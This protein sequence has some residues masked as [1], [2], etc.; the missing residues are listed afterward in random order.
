MKK[1]VAA[2]LLF[3]LCITLCACGSAAPAD[4]AVSDPAVTDASPFSVD[5]SAITSE[6]DSTFAPDENISVEVLY[7]EVLLDLD[8]EGAKYVAE[9]KNT[10][11]F[12]I[13]ISN[14]SIDVEKEDGTLLKVV[15]YISAYPSIIDAGESAFICESIVTMLDSDIT[16]S[17]ATVA[18]LKFK[19]EKAVMPELD[20]ELLTIN[21]TVKTSFPNIVGKVKNNGTEDIS[22]LIVSVPVYSSEGELQTVIYTLVDVAAGE[23]ASFDKRG[24]DVDYRRDFSDS[25]LGKVSLSP[26]W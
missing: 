7:E 11:N 5:T 26:L 19:Y 12:P 6:T 14:V 24:M 22:N 4:T 13:K 10:S 23:E 25:Y 17:E 15:D 1:V 3:T 8:G 9:I 16:A 21:Y 20:V 18:K 2:V